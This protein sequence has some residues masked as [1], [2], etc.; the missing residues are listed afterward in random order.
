MAIT[1]ASGAGKSTLLHLVAGFE[2]PDRGKIKFGPA[3]D[4]D[5]GAQPA[6]ATTPVWSI[7]ADCQ[8]GLFFSFIICSLI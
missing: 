4:R 3:V 1:G 8:I 7:A 6:A 2:A 5:G